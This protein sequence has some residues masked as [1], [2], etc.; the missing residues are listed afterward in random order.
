LNRRRIRAT[1]RPR[2]DHAIVALGFAKDA[3][4][5]DRMLP[6]FQHLVHRVRKIRIMGAAAL[7]LVYVASG[8]FDAYVEHGV[9]LWDIAAGGFIIQRAGGVF[10]R[11][12]VDRDRGFEIVTSGAPL[13]R[14]LHRVQSVSRPT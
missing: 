13:Q 3:R 1:A 9:R 12:P 7:S 14:A 4:S 10:W 2:L 6:V 11:R 5:L 8:R